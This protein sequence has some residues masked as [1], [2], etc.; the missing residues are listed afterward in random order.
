MPPSRR[1]VALVVPVAGFLLGFL[2]FVWIKWVP[3][4]FAE[5]G[6]STATWA[7]AAFALGWW[8]R[9]GAV[10]A[11][12]AA[13]VLLIVAVP[14]YYLAATL[15]QGDDLAVIWALTSFVWMAF[16]VVAGVV[17]GV[18]GIWARTDGWRRVVGTAL[19]VAVFVEEALRFALKSGSYP[20]AWWNVAI[21]LGL[22][23]LLVVLIGRSARVRLLAA[24]VALP[25][26]AA[27]AL[28]FAAVAGS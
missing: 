9:S 7:V 10:R 20:G 13:S 23:V 28:T 18:A 12:V 26:A 2:D 11:A 14:S 25:L 3:F 17:F 22:A 1:A 21:D 6:N 19:P 27:G 4:P 8:I 15:L 5:L 16:G 24:A